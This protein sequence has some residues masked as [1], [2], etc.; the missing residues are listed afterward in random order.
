[1][2]PDPQ[3]LIA[4]TL[5]LLLNGV[6]NGI[7]IHVPALFTRDLCGYRADTG[8]PN[9]SDSNDDLSV[10]LGNV[11]FDQL[12]VPKGKVP[13]IDP[14]TD[15]EH[16]IVACLRNLRPDLRI[17]R[18][19]A[20]TEFA[21]YAHLDVFPQFRRNFGDLRPALADLATRVLA[22]DLGS[23]RARVEKDLQR[24]ATSTEQQALLVGVCCTNW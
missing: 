5:Q 9:T 19:R 22:A 13:P 3:V 18:S 10:E 20:A 4:T 2:Y 7:V 16:L 14:G 11:L 15:M 23:T 24:L 17:E 1:L 21:Q 8:K 12:G 6:K